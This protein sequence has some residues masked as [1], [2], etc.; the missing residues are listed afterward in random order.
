M[1]SKNTLLPN[2]SKPSY[3]FGCT[4]LVEVGEETSHARVSFANLSKPFKYKYKKSKHKYNLVFT[5]LVEV[6][7]EETAGNGGPL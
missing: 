3:N 4:H 5:H 6:G 1:Y 7:A 2:V